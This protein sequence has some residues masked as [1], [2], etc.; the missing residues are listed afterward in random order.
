[1]HEF[2]SAMNRLRDRM[3]MKQQSALL[4]ALLSILVVAAM[5]LATAV[6]IRDR[7]MES[8]K[9]EMQD[10]AQAM[11]DRLDQEMF[12]RFREIGNFA[13]LHPLH[14]SWDSDRDGIRRLLDQLQTTLPRYAWIGYAS[15]DGVVQASTR[16]TLEGVSVAERPWFI[17]ALQAPSALDLHEAKLLADVLGP[18]EDGEPFRFVDVAAPV[19]D[20]SGNVTGVL[21]AHLSWSWAQSVRSYLL[22]SLE[23]R[24]RTDLWVTASDG[25]AI[26]GAPF[27]QPVLSQQQLQLA[28][29]TYIG[30]E[31]DAT[32]LAAAVAT[33]GYESYPG[34]GWIVIAKRPMAVVLADA[35]RFILAIIL[36][37]TF[38]ALAGIGAAFLI[39]GR[40]TRPLNRLT[41][42]ADRLGR[43]EEIVAFGRQRGSSDIL[44]L[45]NS[46]R[47][48]MRRVDAAESDATEARDLM[49]QSERAYSVKTLE[50]LETVRTLRLLADTDPMTGLLN[51]RSFLGDAKDVLAFFRRYESKF[52]ILMIDID[53][54]KHVNDTHGHAVGDEVIR[55][56]GRVLAEAARQTDRVARF[57]GEEFVVLLREVDEAALTSWAERMRSAVQMATVTTPAGAVGVTVSVGATLVS[58][59]DRDIEDVLHR[60][61]LALYRSKSNG[62]NRMTISQGPEAAG[63]P[64]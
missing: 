24:L 6:L 46:L 16:G 50:H 17:D 13:S 62:R 14:D 15:L 52:A 42:D 51:R 7:A 59:G 12:E 47:S 35:N 53:N 5:T 1:M 20:A 31:G 21:G 54:F 38:A 60:A 57:G 22:G 43:E 45:S 4:T 36:I 9:A 39:A 64:A 55:T 29:Q 10:L 30:G 33:K 25:N 61:D 23:P 44:Q 41:A 37:G 58:P 40:V 48:L 27:G 8:A 34:L 49:Q 56:I 63:Q 19:R 11:A 32:Y 26:L 18:S 2:L 28:E 3:S